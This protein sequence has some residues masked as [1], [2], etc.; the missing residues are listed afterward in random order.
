MIFRALFRGAVCG[1]C[2]TSSA[3]PQV[4]PPQPVQWKASLVPGGPVKPGTRATI[5]LSGEVQQ[6]WHVYALTEPAGGPI[7]LHISLDENDVA[8][9]RGTASGTDPIRTNDSSFQMETQLYRGDFTLHMPV[10]V[11][12]PP[13]GKQLIPL[14]VRFQACSDRTCLPPKTV[15]LSIPVEVIPGA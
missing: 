3:V 10:E 1:L 9:I 2:L 12:H 4:G 14:N 7:P 6:G 5:D 8:Q 15:Y 11:K 13:A